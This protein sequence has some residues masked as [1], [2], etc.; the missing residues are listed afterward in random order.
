MN[1]ITHHQPVVTREVGRHM[2]IVRIMCI[3]VQVH[4]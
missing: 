3:Q 2:H 4:A 1:M